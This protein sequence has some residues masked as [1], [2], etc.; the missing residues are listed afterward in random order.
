MAEL[1][2][3][4][5]RVSDD[6]LCRILSSADLGVDPDPKNSWSDQSTMNKIMEY[7]FFG[8]P[9]VAYELTEHR[10]SAGPAALFAEPN[11]EPALAAL[12]QRAARRPRPPPLHGRG[13][14]G[15]GALDPGLGALGAGAAGRLR[16]APAASAPRDQRDTP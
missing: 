5:G 12:H 7:M 3:F 13:R 8:L 11:C 15:A 4:T 14:P 6:D 16:P 1:C 9:V 10:V 2:T